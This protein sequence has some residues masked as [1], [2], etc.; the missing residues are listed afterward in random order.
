ME[1]LT[2]QTVTSYSIFFKPV[3]AFTCSCIIFL[4]F[5]VDC[6]RQIKDQ[7]MKR[8]PLEKDI[9][10]LKRILE[11]DT[12]SNKKSKITGTS[13]YRCYFPLKK[14]T[15]YQCRY[16]NCLR[17]DNQLM[18]CFDLKYKKTNFLMINAIKEGNL[19]LI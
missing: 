2:K 14:S 4:L 11:V 9:K 17:S 3:D 12:V 8:G 1:R 16:K 15:S 7:I 10:N 18:K 6:M 13:Y 5:S 19:K